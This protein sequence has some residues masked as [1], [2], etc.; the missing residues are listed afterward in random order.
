MLLYCGIAGAIMLR[1]LCRF[2]CLV[3]LA[4]LSQQQYIWCLRH[5]RQHVSTKVIDHQ[6]PEKSGTLKKK[7]QSDKLYPPSPPPLFPPSR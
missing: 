1:N 3:E 5:Q 4:E 2:F 6:N 7:L